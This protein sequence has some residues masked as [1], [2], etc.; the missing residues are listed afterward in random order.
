MTTN[1]A[2]QLWQE[3]IDLLMRVQSEPD[4]QAALKTLERWRARS[5]EHETAW[6]EA[7]RIYDLSGKALAPQ[8]GATERQG[9][10]R[11]RVLVGAG[12]GLA[13]AAS[14]A[15]APRVLPEPAGTHATRT[16]EFRSVAMA[17]G[18]T[19]DLGPSTRLIVTD[20]AQ[21]RHIELQSG[22]VYCRVAPDRR[23]PFEVV[24]ADV[25]TVAI[26]T[27]FDV[28]A[29]SSVVQVSVEEGSVVVSDMSALR[30]GS[31]LQP[32][33]WLTVDTESHL[34]ARGQRDT[35]AFA[36][37]RSGRIVADAERIDAVIDSI[38]RWYAGKIILADASIG[39]EVVS[40][41]F[42]ARQT[43]PALQAA[44]APYGAN[45]RQISPWF[46]VISRI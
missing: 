12:V 18:S 37:W 4:N 1:K 35:G 14:I 19:L 20:S 31:A 2:D 23:R 13:A 3:A 15:I 8:Q 45:V 17:D 28:T 33:Q 34:I 29:N 16:G 6:N 41:V 36:S 24:A 26:G 7:V 32:G 10:G 25:T 40:G 38:S 21:R 43:L 39:R 27:A 42:D 11:R 5:S 46:I 44:V 9:V 30:R 22:M